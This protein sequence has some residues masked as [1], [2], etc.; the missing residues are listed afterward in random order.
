MAERPELADDPGTRAEEGP[1]NGSASRS[2]GGVPLL[3]RPSPAGFRRRHA[4]RGRPALLQGLAGLWP[5]VSRWSPEF[6]RKA[7]PDASVRY[8]EREAAPPPSMLE[9]ARGRRRVDASLGEFVERM[10]LE[11]GRLRYLIFSTLVQDHLE[12]RKDL[13]SLAPYQLS[14]RLPRS[15]RRGLV[16]EPLFWMG[17]RSVFSPIHFDAV[18]NL[19]VQV[20]GHKEWR[21][22]PPSQSRNVY[23]P[24]DGHPDEFLNWSPVDPERPDPERFPLFAEAEPL[25]V[26]V[27]PGDVLYVPAG[28]WHVVRYDE[29]AISLTYFWHGPW[30]STVGCR[31]FHR[32]RLRR[33][34]GLAARPA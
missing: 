25:R 14:E 4:N 26:T 10:T 18:D 17:P 2:E 32:E 22:W 31:H 9:L 8:I 16:Q 12:L 3:H 15:L 7:L 30:T 34:L 13:G 20:H 11:D 1:M 21:L 28:W 24:F 5:A 29:P 23:Y 33:K 27:A 6:F 19:F